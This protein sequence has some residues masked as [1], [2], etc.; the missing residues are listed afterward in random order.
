MKLTFTLFINQLFNQDSNLTKSISRSIEANTYQ[1]HH[2]E[3]SQL[4][5]YFLKAKRM[6][7]ITNTRY[8][9][10]VGNC[11]DEQTCL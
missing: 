4:R 5:L 7:G 1:V 10:K 3:D 6:R 8:T 2:N 9:Q 11:R